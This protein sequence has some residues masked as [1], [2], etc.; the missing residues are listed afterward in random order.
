V[1]EA[2]DLKSFYRF[3]NALKIDTKEQGEI[4]LGKSLMG[5][6]TW[7]INEITKGMDEGIRNFVT[8]KCRQIGISTISLAFDLFWLFRYR[9][10]NGMLVTHD[11]PARDAFRVTLDMYYAG[12]PEEFK[13]ERLINNRNAMIFKNKSRLNF[14]VAGTKAKGGGALGRS[15][16][17]P[18]LHATE[19]SSWGDPEGL[20]SLQ[21]SLAETNPLRFY[22]WEST[23][24]GFNWFYDMWEEAKRAVTQK[25]IFVSFWANQYY[26]APRHSDIWKTYWG[27]KG[28][29]HADEREWVREVKSLYGVEI[30]DTQMAWWR[31]KLA[32]S[33]GDEAMMMK[34]VPPTENHAFIATGS[35]FFTAASISQGYKLERG[36]E[37]PRNFRIQIGTHFADTVL[38]ATPEKLATLRVWEEPQVKGQYVLGA[39]PAYG[40]SEW[41][42]RFCCSVWR[43]Y[44]DRLVQVAEFVD[45]DMATYS[46]AWV[47]AYL[48]GAYEP[49]L[50]NLEINGPGQG[51]LSELQNMRRAIV[52][53]GRD[54]NSG[55]DARTLMSVTKN[56]SSYLYRRL[57]TFSGPGAI[58]TLMGHEMKERMLNT[59]RDYYERDM[60]VV[61]SR[62]LLDE[63]K[64]I[65]RTGGSAPAA[66]GRSKD[67]RVIAGALAALA[68]NDQ[69]RT[70][71]MTQNATYELVTAAEGK[72]PGGVVDRMVANYLKKL[73]VKPQQVRR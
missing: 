2:F 32:E 4:Y 53:S 67:D 63:M 30:D 36:Y 13:R 66:T 11:E 73:G 64:S 38:L 60:L 5:T 62:G 48:A 25:A 19:M 3:C 20:K 41:A 57:D 31:W 21:A 50:V 6:Q 26:R 58:H 69:I 9:A 52:A 15:A 8:L 22:H 40:S 14:R 46:F 59:Y 43:C 16:A 47:L 7:V 1:S 24:R 55:R 54:G 37:R 70:K 39:D 68:W 18:F 35:Q 61:K 29:L 49:C 10:I 34:E 12:L 72:G 45:P 65:E 44:A 71:M 17:L 56:I 33:I 42:D 28:R 51:V 27:F 23:A